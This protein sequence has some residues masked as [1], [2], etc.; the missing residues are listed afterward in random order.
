MRNLIVY[1]LYLSI[2]F[3]SCTSI[4]KIN[5]NTSALIHTKWKYVDTDWQYE[6]EFKKNGQ[7]LTTHPN[8]HSIGNDTWVQSDKQINFYYNDKF[9]I[10][11]GKLVTEDTIKGSG[12]NKKGSWEF[13]M[14]KLK[15]GSKNP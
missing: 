3:T 9:A 5:P 13:T 6:I 7:L 1:I 2:A 14:Y 10:Y 12:M 15:S 4:K 11:K 8:D